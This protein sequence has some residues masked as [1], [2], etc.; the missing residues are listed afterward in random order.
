MHLMLM[1]LRRRLK[2][3]VSSPALCPAKI[4]SEAPSRD[5]TRHWP[6]SVCLSFLDP[7]TA[8][9]SA[10]LILSAA[11]ASRADPDKSSFNRLSNLFRHASL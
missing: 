1:I 5:D 4:S 9:D 11:A 7:S 2:V 10:R 8:S 3:V 6:S